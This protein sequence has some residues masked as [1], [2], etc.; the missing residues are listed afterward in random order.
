ML[1]C[2]RAQVAVVKHWCPASEAGRAQAAACAQQR[3]GRALQFL[4]SRWGAVPSGG[5][6][7]W[8]SCPL[9]DSVGFPTPAPLVT[10]PSAVSML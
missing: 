8:L 2:V 1:T 7:A 9:G 10:S 6:L 5:R 3:G 4:G